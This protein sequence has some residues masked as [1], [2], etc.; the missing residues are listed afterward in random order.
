MSGPLDD[1]WR[2]SY[3]VREEYQRQEGECQGK[4]TYTQ[5]TVFAP[6]PRKQEDPPIEDMPHK[7][8]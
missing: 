1:D 4:S 7:S 8:A 2:R 5:G 6:G 3:H